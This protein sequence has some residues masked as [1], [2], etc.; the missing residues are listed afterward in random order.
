MNFKY[1]YIGELPVNVAELKERGIIGD[2]EVIV[3]DDEVEIEDKFKSVIL[4]MNI[5]PLFVRS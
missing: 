1:K 3:K 5:C 4:A 2:S